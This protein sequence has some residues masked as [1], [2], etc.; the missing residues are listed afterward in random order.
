MGP[1]SRA[2]GRFESCLPKPPRGPRIE[3]TRLMD[4]TQLNSMNIYEQHLSQKGY[5]RAEMRAPS[6]Q[7]RT[8]PCKI[9]ARYFETEEQYQN[10]LH[11]FLNGN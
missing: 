6:R 10:A 11:D 5:S 3:Y 1:K 4:K 2:S 8:F 7:K 9:G